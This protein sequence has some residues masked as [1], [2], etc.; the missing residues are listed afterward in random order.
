MTSMTLR[1]IL[2]QGMMMVKGM[3]SSCHGV[4]TAPVTSSNNSIINLH[5]KESDF[6][7]QKKISIFIQTF[8][9]NNTPLI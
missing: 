7:S 9:H 1:V 8:F 6:S 2:P 4:V 3:T 5:S